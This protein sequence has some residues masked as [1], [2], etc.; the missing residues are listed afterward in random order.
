MAVTAPYNAVDIGRMGSFNDGDSDYGSDFSA[1]EE[2]LVDEIL[3]E[4]SANHRP[5]AVPATAIMTAT[6]VATTTRTQGQSDQ[7]R[8]PFPV[9]VRSP[10]PLVSTGN[11]APAI[12]LTRALPP[13]DG[14]EDKRKS[15]LDQHR[16][17]L[18]GSVQ[19]PDL[20]S[21]L[22]NLQPQ[23]KP[24][25][26]SESLPESQQQQQQQQ[27]QQETTSPTPKKQSVPELGPDART[28]LQ[29]FR[30]F[31]RRPLTVT[32][33]AAG[34]WCELQH[35]YT[36][37]RLPG[38]K[39]TITAAMRGGSRV[40]QT[41]EDEVHSA[42]QVTV[43]SREEAFALR[44]W[45]IIQGVRTLRDT[46][47]TRE[48]EVWGTVEGEVLNGVIDQLNHESPNAS[49]EEELN[50]TSSSASS[51][52]P[53]IT[54]YLG[55]SHKTVYL[56]DVKTRGSDRL[57]TGTA[58]RPARV[59]LF[60]Y[61]RLLSDMAADKLDYAAIFKRY[62]L[63]GEAHFSDAF[64]AQIGGLHD[65][66]F[67]DADS[68]IEDIPPEIYSPDLIGYR[69]ISQIIPL[70]KAELRETFP[71]GPASISNLLAVQYR[72]RDDGRIIGNNSFPNDPEALDAYM[73]E[74]LRWWRG[75]REPEGV[76]I[77]ETYKCGWCE[78]A[79]TCQWRKDK[80]AE[81]LKRKKRGRANANHV[82][83]TP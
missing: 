26:K 33:M 3:A 59:Q 53:S 15:G 23:S 43:A 56:T 27:Q 22:S 67:Y 11:S 83:P 45:N 54:D 5:V 47:I 71:L 69:S 79:E 62:G 28:P 21:A 73:K 60:L 48:L 68:D 44:L 52:Q 64:I 46:G 7:S 34:A 1:G 82:P 70:L 55:S 41:L 4:L 31:P 20:S 49:F 81:F 6:T 78:F 2:Q 35:W 30:S 39:R 25:P 29:R 18:L 17:S 8:A 65:E 24:E 13:S 75:E 50:L 61:H 9:S 14:K 74:N 80:E 37:T 36:L 51:Q 12:G 42:V 72:H 10:N 66:I 38:G 32:D 76:T 16:A 63:D 57:P 40:H 77:E 58:L 19:Y